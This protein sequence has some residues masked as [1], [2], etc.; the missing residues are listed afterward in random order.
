MKTKEKQYDIGVIV[1][2]FQTN[3]LHQ[4]HKALFNTVL[5]KHTKVIVFLGV[6]SAFGT[7]KDPLDFASRSEMIKEDYGDK[8]SAILPI[9]DIKKNDYIWSGNIDEKIREVFP[10]GNVVLYG[11]RDSFIPY[12]KGVFDTCELDAEEKVSATS[13]RKEVSNIVEKNSSFRA[14]MIYSAYNTYPHV[15]PTVDIAIVNKDETQVLLGRKPYE[16]EFRFVG[17]FTDV[18]DNSYEHAAS[19][20]AREETG[21]E[22]GHMQYLG[23]TNVNDKR[24][25]G[26]DDRAIMTIFFKAKYIFGDPKGMDDIAEVSW[27]KLNELKPEDLVIEHRKLLPLLNPKPIS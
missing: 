17:G 19:R 25:E 24:Y 27:R 13:I 10:M 8:I 16:S 14:G 3:R 5:S 6:G 4:Q 2:R 1:G 9:R 12:Y 18:T 22:V 11:G 26:H 20:E 21:L 15:Y 7:R 23:S